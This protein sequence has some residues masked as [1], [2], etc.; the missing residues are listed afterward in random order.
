MVYYELNK[1][2]RAKYVGLLFTSVSENS[3]RRTLYVSIDAP[4]PTQNF[5]YPPTGSLAE[6]RHY[7]GTSMPWLYA[8]NATIVIARINSYYIDFVWF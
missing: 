2:F 4:F 6:V 1:L 7:P 8:D 3:L 5:N